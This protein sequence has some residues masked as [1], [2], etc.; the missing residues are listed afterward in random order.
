[1]PSDKVML[2]HCDDSDQR[3]H[4]FCDGQRL[5]ITANNLVRSYLLISAENYGVRL[6][7]VDEGNVTALT[8]ATRYS[9]RFYAGDQLVATFG[10]FVLVDEPYTKLIWSA[11]LQDSVLCA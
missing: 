5:Y 1:M 3:Q 8:N 2:A 4:W 6:S 11:A 7:L 10:E 9:S